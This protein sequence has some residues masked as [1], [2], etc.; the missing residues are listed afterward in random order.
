M[1]EEKKSAKT[2][3]TETVTIIVPR[4]YAGDKRRFVKVGGRKYSIKTGEPVE[5]PRAVARI[6]VQSVEAR[7][8]RIRMQE[9][10]EAENQSPGQ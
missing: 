3:A 1:A 5:L 4:R 8:A 10:L 2:A 6:V 7:E 9:R